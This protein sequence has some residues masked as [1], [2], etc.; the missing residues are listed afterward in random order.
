MSAAASST[1]YKQ[2]D[3]YSYKDSAQEKTDSDGQQEK[4]RDGGW[5][6]GESKC[7]GK[8]EAKFEPDE[9][10]EVSK[11]AK[12]YFDAD[13]GEAPPKLD[14]SAEERCRLT[15]TFTS[16]ARYEGDWLRGMRD[17]M[18]KQVWNDGTEYIGEWMRGRAHGKGRLLHSDGDVYTGLW[19][20]GRAHGLGVFEFQNGAAVFCGE[21]QNDLREG[22]GEERWQEGSVYVGEFRKGMKS[23]FG[24]NTWPDGSARFSGRWCRN[25]LKGPGCFQVEG[26]PVYKGEW[27]QSAP[28]GI[29]RYEFADGSKY[30][31]RYMMDK[32]HGFGVFTD[33][34][35]GEV[36]GFWE[37]GELKKSRPAK[38]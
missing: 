25:E 1:S 12:T 29:G 6:P 8:L 19:V 13:V 18:G 4:L 15:Y 7:M 33:M 21:F 36:H 34:D 9:P 35:G 31:G 23:G 3:A 2:S 11:P 26:G 38:E 16:G 10:I 22:R 27:E 5:S 14:G 32:K 30:E 20:N 24:E 28:C 17:G 37:Q